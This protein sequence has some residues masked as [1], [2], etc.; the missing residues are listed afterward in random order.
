M[1]QLSGTA[2]EGAG[3]AVSTGGIGL[4]GLGDLRPGASASAFDV[5][6][7][8][9]R[10]ALGNH[11]RAVVLILASDAE[12]TSLYDAEQVRGYL[13]ALGV[14][15]AVWSVDPERTG[16]GPW[17]ESRDVSDFPKLRRAVAELSEDLDRQAIAWVD[18][19]YLPQ[20]VSVG[21]SRRVERVE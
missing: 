16:S 6:R 11:R 4:S 12:E 17:G 15:L 18:G 3:S 5:M 20:A 13:R 14:P 9:L 1:A 21:P 7:R 19:T 10:A 8:G 2:N